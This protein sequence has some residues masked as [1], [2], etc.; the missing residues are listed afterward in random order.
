MTTK[1]PLLS[2]LYPDRFPVQETRVEAPRPVDS[3]PM[4]LRRDNAKD[5]TG[6]VR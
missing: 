3:R 4:W 6:R 5:M 2:R 1:T